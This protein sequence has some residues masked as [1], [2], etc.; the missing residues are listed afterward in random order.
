MLTKYA[1]HKYKL[2]LLIFA[3]NDPGFQKK[4]RVR[5]ASLNEMKQSLHLKLEM[6]FQQSLQNL[7]IP[8]Q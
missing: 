4:G 8:W 6:K 3:P 7:T 1:Q 5:I 2:T